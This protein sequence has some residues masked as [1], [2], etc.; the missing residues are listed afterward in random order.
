MTTTHLLPGNNIIIKTVFEAVAHVTAKTGDCIMRYEIQNPTIL[1]Q[2]MVQIR[3]VVLRLLYNRYQIP[4]TKLKAMFRLS[5]SKISELINAEPY[6]SE[7][8]LKEK[9]IAEIFDIYKRNQYANTLIK[10]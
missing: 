2:E 4:Q 8:K 5:G 9:I 6:L 1:S 7:L 10:Q 3:K